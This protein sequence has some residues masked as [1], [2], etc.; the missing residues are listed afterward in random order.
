MLT[1]DTGGGYVGEKEKVDIL[2][3]VKVLMLLI[4][5]VYCLSTVVQDY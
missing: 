4:N 5:R 2:E 3:T 1:I